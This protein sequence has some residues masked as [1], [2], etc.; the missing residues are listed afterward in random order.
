MRFKNRLISSYQNK[1]YRKTND[2]FYYHEFLKNI[3]KFFNYKEKL[4]ILDIGCGSG[5]LS[6]FLSKKFLNSEFYCI[7]KDSKNIIYAKNMVKKLNLKTKINFTC[8]DFGKFSSKEKFDLVICSGFLCFFSDFK[9]PLNKMLKFIKNKRSKI[10]IF[11]DFNSSGVDKIVKFK[12]TNHAKTG[13]WMEG[14]TSYSI[15]T[16]K[17]YLLK[18]KYKLKEIRFKLPKN[19]GKFKGDPVRSISR[20][21]QGYGRLI[22]NK[23]NLIFEFYTLIISKK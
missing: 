16:I 9:Q 2:R 22:F 12:S 18:K 14:F 4:K 6:I 23:A 21:L 17:N 13:V 19:I 3:S 10:M 15:K 20:I 7:D 1:V 11:G 8:K 5:G